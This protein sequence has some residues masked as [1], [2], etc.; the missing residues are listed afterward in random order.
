MNEANLGIAIVV[1]LFAGL[2]TAIGSAVAF[3]AKRTNHRLLAIALAFSAGVMLY[4]SFTEILGK[5]HASLT[6][7]LGDDLAAWWTAAAFFG[8]M[9]VIAVIDRLVPQEE[10]PHET[11]DPVDLAEVRSGRR[12][13]DPARAAKLARMGKLAALAIAIHNFPEGMATFFSTLDDPT[14]GIAIAIAIALHNIPEGVSVS[15]PLYYATGNRMTAFLWSVLSG[16]A[17]PVGALLG[18]FILKPYFTPQI[19][20]ALFAAVAGIMVFVSLD[21]LLPTA[22]EYGQGHEVIYSLIAGMGVMAMSLLLLR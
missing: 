15:V 7:P 21:E 13:P 5:A 19:E 22:R 18:Y 3:F 16:L 1:T 14:V 9:A 4:V 6:G 8:G 10:N 20:G 17:E 12:P 11:R 2:S